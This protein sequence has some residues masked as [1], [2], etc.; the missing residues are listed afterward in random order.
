MGTVKLAEKTVK[1]RAFSLNFTDVAQ[2]PFV[3]C[4]VL[5]RFK[6]TPD[7]CGQI[8]LCFIKVRV[9]LF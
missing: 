8:T 3:Y 1:K 7:F 4:R 5:L 9:I 2:C 6:V